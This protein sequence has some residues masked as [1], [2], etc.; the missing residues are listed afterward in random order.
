MYP[1]IYGSRRQAVTH[2]Q[3]MSMQLSLWQHTLENNADVVKILS[4]DDRQQLAYLFNTL[5]D[6]L[7]YFQAKAFG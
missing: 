1:M 4:T 3:Q 2:L 7:A 5:Q 6:H